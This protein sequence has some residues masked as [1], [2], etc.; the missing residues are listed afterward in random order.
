MGSWKIIEMRL[1]RMRRIWDSENF[2]R[3][4]PSKTTSPP[5]ILPGGFGMGGVGG[6]GERIAQAVAQQVAPEYRSQYLQ[7]REGHHPGGPQDQGAAAGDVFAPFRSRRLG[8][9]AQNAQGGRI[10][11]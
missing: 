10:Q 5:T 3:S 9:A 2:R 6:R 7:P 4:C 1:P 11:E 8:P